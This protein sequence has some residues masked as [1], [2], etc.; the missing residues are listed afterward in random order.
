MRLRLVHRCAAQDQ[1]LPTTILYANTLAH[2]SFL[3]AIMSTSTRTASFCVSSFYRPTARPRRAS[4]PSDCQRN[5][6]ATTV[7][8]TAHR[9]GWIHI[10]K[11][12]KTGLVIV[13][14]ERKTGPILL[15][16]DSGN[17]QRLQPQWAPGLLVGFPCVSLSSVGH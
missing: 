8:G 11:A 17:H 6:T 9:A 14:K 1:R 10:R 5:N 15:L 16:I 7:P 3:P 2:I 4:L 13:R 12:R